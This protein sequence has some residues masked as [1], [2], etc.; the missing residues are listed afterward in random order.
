MPGTGRIHLPRG[1]K[2]SPG[3]LSLFGAPRGDQDPHPSRRDQTVYSLAMRWGMAW[4]LILLSLCP[5]LRALEGRLLFPD[6]TPVAGAQV[7]I[8]E[9]P[10][11]SRTDR[12]GRFRWSPDPPVPFEVRVELPGGHDTLHIVVREAVPEGTLE[13]VVRPLFREDL[14]VTAGVPIRTGTTPANAL[15]L[16]TQEQLAQSRPARLIEAIEG[17][18]GV[19]RIS[20]GHAGVPSI[21]GLARGRTLILLNGSRVISERRVGPG[22]SYLDPFFLDRVE[23]VRGPGSVAYGSDAFGGVIHALTRKPD[24]ESDYGARFLGSLGYGMPEQSAGLELSRSLESGSVFF[25]GSLRNYGDYRSSGVTVDNSSARN[26]SFLTGA[27]FQSGAGELSLGWQTDR[28]HDLGRPTLRSPQMRT[29]YPDES[30]DRMNLAFEPRPVAGFDRIRIEGSMGRYALITDRERLPSPDQGRELRRSRVSA[31]HFDFRVQA[32]SPL[33]WARLELG[34]DVNGRFG[35]HSENTTR[36]FDA[37]NRPTGTHVAASIE[38]ASRIVLAPFLSA[39][40]TVN[41]FLSFWAGGRWDQVSSTSRGSLGDFNRIGRALSG[42]LAI[43]AR[44]LPPLQLTAQLSRGFREPTLSDRYFQGV[45]GRGLVHGNPNLAPETSRQ[46]D[47]SARWSGNDWRWDLFLYRYE[48]RHLVERFEA[49]PGRFFFRNRGAALLSGVEME[50]HRQ[51]GEGLSV[52]LGGHVAR[53]RTQEDGNPLDDVPA[54]ALTLIVG[55]TLGSRSHLRLHGRTF[56]R[57]SRAGPTEAPTPGFGTLDLSWSWLLDSRTQLRFR[58]RNLTD[59]DYPASPDRW[60]VPAPGRSLLL[61]LMY[62][63]NNR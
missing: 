14:T 28:G 44:P 18:P 53:G 9:H 1:L 7:T 49:Q 12:E 15:D 47:V 21:R 22:A 51:F 24:P 62:N 17:I 4:A 19:G 5:A 23:V 59:K 57:D 26:R 34:F 11:Q 42:Y 31:R 8:L 52:G 56:S 55:K 36:D 45:S 46:W 40:V 58:V 54:P 3:R 43:V 32:A 61:T 25:L 50:L 38:D 16:V 41:S 20:A 60:S 33:E 13:M 29:F 39:E 48:I 37:R 30:S 2:T 27:Q 35:L 6:G 10:G 63:L